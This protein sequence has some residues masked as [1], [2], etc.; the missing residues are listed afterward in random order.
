MGTACILNGMG[1]EP[2]HFTVERSY[3]GDICIEV[4]SQY[5]SIFLVEVLVTGTIRK[6]PQKDRKKISC[7]NSHASVWFSCYFWKLLET[8]EKVLQFQWQIVA[9]T[10]AFCRACTTQILT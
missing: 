10:K 6:G 1:T 3:L 8:S 2:S 7:I 4:W 5:V 9:L